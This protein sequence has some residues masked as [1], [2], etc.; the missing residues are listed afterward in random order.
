MGTYCAIH[1]KVP[2]KAPLVSEFE[3][4]LAETHRGQ[5]IQTAIAETFGPLYGDEFLCSTKE[6][7]KFA[8]ISE[9]PGWVTAHFN[10]FYQ[11]RNLATDLSAKLSTI[12]IAVLAQTCSSAYHLIICGS[13]RHLRSRSAKTLP[14]RERRRGTFLRASPIASIAITMV[15]SFGPTPGWTHPIPSLRLSVHSRR[16]FTPQRRGNE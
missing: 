11:P 15:S 14:G 13:G 2:E 8:L 3:R 4:F 7:T 10:S 9:Q 12:V 6:P 5:V 1:V 16:A